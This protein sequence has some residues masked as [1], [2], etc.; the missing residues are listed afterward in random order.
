M[1]VV[2]H[3]SLLAFLTGR[4]GITNIGQITFR[5]NAQQIFIQGQI[6]DTLSYLLPYLRIR[7]GL[8]GSC[9]DCILRMASSMH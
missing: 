6:F 2:T 1:T 5:R 7:T 3:S 4:L 9:Y 8:L